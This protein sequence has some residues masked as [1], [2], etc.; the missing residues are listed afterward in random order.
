M[1]YVIAVMALTLLA[2][3]ASRTEL[4]AKDSSTCSDIG[5]ASD[6]VDHKKCV[7]D[8]QAARLQGHHDRYYR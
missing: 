1:Q 6:S 5:F 8:L 4:L 3:C 7:Q 2:G